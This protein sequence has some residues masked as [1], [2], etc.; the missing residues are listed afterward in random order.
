MS[1]RRPTEAGDQMIQRGS[2][3]PAA[4]LIDRR[5]TIADLGRPPNADWADR[6]H[7]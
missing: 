1:D 6:P 7:V 5:P 4:G 3:P 2:A